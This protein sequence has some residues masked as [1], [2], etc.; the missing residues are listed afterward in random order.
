M[1]YVPWQCPSRIEGL[2]Q[3]LRLPLAARWRHHRTFGPI[4]AG[5]LSSHLTCMKD[6][7]DSIGS[8]EFL[9]MLTPRPCFPLHLRRAGPYACVSESRRQES[10]KQS[11]QSY[12]THLRRFLGPSCTHRASSRHWLD[13]TRVWHVSATS[14]NRTTNSAVSRMV[15]RRSVCL[16]HV[17]L[18]HDFT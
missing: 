11:T 9:D 13:F 5:R 4:L 17:K 14:I 8:R 3:Y 2:R 18:L 10:I 1:P 12:H 16:A 15:V 7:S 6:G